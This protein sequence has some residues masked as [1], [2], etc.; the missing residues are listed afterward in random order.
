M[1]IR[2]KTALVT[3]GAGGI[4]SAITRALVREG[5]H[6]TISFVENL[7]GD[8]EAAEQLLSECRRQV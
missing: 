4:G 6:V 5:V 8:Q 2:G 7:E 3:G 1:E